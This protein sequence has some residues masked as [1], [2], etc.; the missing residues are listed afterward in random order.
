MIRLCAR[1]TLDAA[2]SGVKA[3]ARSVRVNALTWWLLT[4]HILDAAASEV[5]TEALAVRGV[6][7]VSCF[8]AKTL[9]RRSRRFVVGVVRTAQM[10]SKAQEDTKQNDGRAVGK[11]KIKLSLA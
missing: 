7:R 9:L 10:V 1:P 11:E 5:K 3:E 8:F 4:R 6:S 2:A